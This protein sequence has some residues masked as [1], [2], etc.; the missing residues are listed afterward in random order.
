M[1]ELERIRQLV[2]MMVA[3]DLMEVTIKHGEEELV[4]RR[5]GP[6]SGAPVA[7]QPAMMHAVPMT[8][9]AASPAP[10]VAAAAHDDALIR[11]TSPMVG[12][13]YA[14]PSPGAAAF[15]KVGQ[16]IHPDTVVC[17][18]EAMKVFNEIK[19]ETHGVI[20]KIYVANEQAVEY[21]QPLFGV[22]RP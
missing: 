20:E 11:I 14:S 7:V 3:N 12:K 2:E 21:G 17:I 9:P 16:E 19:A 5:P 1:D 13:F 6:A 22:R 8:A 10:S 18:I 4:L 15:V